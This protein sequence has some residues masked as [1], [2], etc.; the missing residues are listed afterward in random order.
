MD[1][2]AV[3]I[4]DQAELSPEVFL[5][6]ESKFDQDTDLLCADRTIID[7]GDHEKVGAR[8]SFANMSTV[9]RLHLMSY[10][11]LMEFIKDTYKRWRKTFDLS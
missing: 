11:S 10:V 7:G 8:K 9:I 3:V 5:E 1:D 4:A 6:S 2:R